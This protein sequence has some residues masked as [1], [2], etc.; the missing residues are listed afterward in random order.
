MRFE[1][2]P[3]GAFFTMYDEADSTLCV[4]ESKDSSSKGY[5]TYR[6]AGSTQPHAPYLMRHDCDVTP[7]SD[8]IV[9]RRDTTS[10]DLVAFM[11]DAE[12]NPGMLVCYAHVGQ[13]SEACRE[14]YYSTKP[15]PYDLP[16]VQQLTRE[17]VSMGYAVHLVK[18]QPSWRVSAR[19]AS[20][21]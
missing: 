7:R 1:H 8:A 15:V 16:E 10:G 12:A 2:L 6:Y 14:Y 4:K 3:V 5:G 20:I 9:I 21:A 13:H 19:R 18:R 11:P 17:L